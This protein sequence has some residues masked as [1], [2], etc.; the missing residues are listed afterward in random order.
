MM[1]WGTSWI[2]QSTPEF[3]TDGMWN[4]C[5]EKCIGWQGDYIEKQVCQFVPTM[6]YFQF[7]CQYIVSFSG[8]LT[9][10]ITYHS[11]PMELQFWLIQYWYM[12]IQWLF[13]QETQ[14]HFSNFPWM[15]GFLMKMYMA[16]AYVYWSR[17]HAPLKE[18]DSTCYLETQ[19][20]SRCVAECRVT[21]GDTNMYPVEQH[22]FKD[23][24]WF[25]LSGYVNSQN[26]RVGRTE[27]AWT[28]H[29]ENWGV[30]CLFL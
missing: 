24:A 20:P 28:S 7:M 25:R 10:C 22:V 15:Y 29:R 8:Y 18:M 26:M 13:C 3:C 12:H 16:K 1:K 17:T 19:Q 4:L 21:V 5:Q 27:P 6:L 23:E 9:V 2:K 14:T 11:L 30:V